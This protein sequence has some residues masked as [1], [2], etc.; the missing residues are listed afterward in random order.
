MRD[1]YD[2]GRYQERKKDTYV[3]V[4][5]SHH[6]PSPYDARVHTREMRKKRAWRTAQWY[7][8]LL[9]GVK[10]I[11]RGKLK[12]EKKKMGGRG[13]NSILFLSS[14]APA[15]LGLNHRFKHQFLSKYATSSPTGAR[16]LPVMTLG[17]GG[18][19]LAR[20]SLS[21]RRMTRGSRNSPADAKD[22]VDIAERDVRAGRVDPPPPP[23]PLP[24][25]PLP[26]PPPPDSSSP[27]RPVL[28]ARPYSRSGFVRVAA[29]ATL[30]GPTLPLP[31]PLPPAFGLP[32]SV[33]ERGRTR[34]GG[35]RRG[36]ESALVSVSFPFPFPT[37]R[38]NASATTPFVVR[39]A[40]VVCRPAERP[41]VRPTASSSSVSSSFTE[42]GDGDGDE[43]RRGFMIGSPSATV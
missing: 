18:T 12:S 21:S 11:A 29:A 25:L 13:F 31:L 20:A 15:F 7:Q 2:K 8:S 36:A 38:P 34:R 5:S 14:S 28:I 16:G 17:A 35:E 9:K 1:K 41:M 43:D 19:A 10:V 33:C 32:M 42:I 40:P 26:L 39:T 6:V 37:P 24:P 22:V 3:G 30:G 23:P 27:R 4:Q